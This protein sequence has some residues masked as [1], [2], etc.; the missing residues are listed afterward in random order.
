MRGAP[1]LVLV[2][3]VTAGF[4]PVPELTPAT[5]GA[6]ERYVA[7]TERRIQAERADRAPLFWLDRQPDRVRS[8]A[9]QRL[10]RGQVVVESVETRDA[11]QTIDV[12]SG[13]IHHWVATALIPGTT[14]DR[15][16]AVV[17][18]YD[19][20]P[21]VFAP[22]MTR[23]RVVERR[24]ARD[25]VALRTSVQKLV[26]V[27]MEG[28]Y[29]MEYARVG[30]DRAT[31]TTIATNLHQVLNEG[32]ADER[33]EPADRT[34]GY[35][36]RYRMYCAFEQRPEGVLDQCESLTLTRTVPGLVSWLIGGTVA[37]IPRDSLS[38]MLA[39]TRRT[40]VK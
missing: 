9:R 8:S 36:W 37:A 4:P 21:Q 12:P 2:A 5:L 30:P 32:R 38:L 25:V 15:V 28:D 14:V 27:V 31:T 6:Y 35:L 26:S 34:A 19:R 39:G 17:R 22:L 16:L 23:V 10:Q 1:G 24:D 29:V 13:R 33:R 18:D 7:L 3:V 11:G 20:Y 40:L